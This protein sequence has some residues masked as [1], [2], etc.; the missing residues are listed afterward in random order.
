MRVA[1]T[2]L[3]C[4]CPLGA[5]LSATAAALRDARDGIT[6]VTAFDVSACRSRTAGQVDESSLAR[7]ADITPRAR[8]W[9]RASR[10]LLLA[11]AEALAGRNDLQPDAAIIATTCGGMDAGEEFYRTRRDRSS[12]HR[13]AHLVHDYVPQQPARN[14]LEAF[15]IDAPPRI[16]SNACASGTNA[17]GQAFHL[18]RS[19]R[20]RRVLCGGY[21]ALCQLVFAGFSSLQAA[22]GDLCRPFDAGR[23]G[24]VLGEGAAVLVLEPLEEATAPVFAEI[25]GYGTSSDNHHLTQPN[26]DG[27]GPRLAMERALADA[28]WT[29][30]DVDYVNAHGTATPFNDAS[31]ARALAQVC[32]HSAVSSTKGQMGHALGAAGAIEAA[33]CVLAL[34]EGFLP[35]NINFRS[36]DEGVALDLV[37]N[38]PRPATPRRVLSNSLGFG[39]ANA[40]LAI[41]AVES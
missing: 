16:V 35:A 38:A 9:N 41:Q 7:A 31:E 8:R 37:A 36:P 3:G 34:R 13:A 17:I 4:I 24:L 15:E 5:D 28:G 25:A 10:M 1:I 21:D 39:G 11:T 18:V 22:T 14:A 40:T 26:P 27:S 2:G 32:P 20:A 19:G 33:F 12:T 30:A 23:T 6:P 29:G